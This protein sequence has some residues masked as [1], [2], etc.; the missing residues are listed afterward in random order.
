MSKARIIGAGSA[1]S[2]IYHCNVNLDTAG[3]TKK[4]GLPYLLT[5]QTYN[6]R[7]V[8]VKAVGN[9]RDTIFTINQ[10]GGIGRVEWYPQD[11]VRNRPPYK[12]VPAAYPKNS[13][14][15]TTPPSKHLGR[16]WNGRPINL[17]YKGQ[18]PAVLS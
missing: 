14:A 1:G 3:G 10:L 15:P 18:R 13:N 16:N 9:N 6:K 11:G 17:N 2:T 8:S 7:W 5:G 12:Y 4:Q